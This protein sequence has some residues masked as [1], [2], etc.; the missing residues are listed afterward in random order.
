M[1]VWSMFESARGL[2]T[3]VGVAPNRA[4]RRAGIAAIA[5][6]HR[7]GRKLVRKA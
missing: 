3:V 6:V 7:A 2:G 5:A 1:A 4:H